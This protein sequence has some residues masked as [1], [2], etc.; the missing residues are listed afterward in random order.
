MKKVLLIV[1]VGLS[2]ALTTSFL[3]CNKCPKPINANG[4]KTVLYSGALKI[5]D[6]ILNNSGNLHNLHLDS[7]SILIDNYGEIDSQI[8][9][10]TM[11]RYIEKLAS[12]YGDNN[13]LVS[14]KENAAYGRSV[15]VINQIKT[16]LENTPVLGSAYADIK[17]LLRNTGSKDEFKAGLLNIYANYERGCPPQYKIRLS[18]MVSVAYSSYQYWE[19]NYDGWVDR[20]IMITMGKGDDDKKKKEEEER[21]KREMQAQKEQRIANLVQADLAGAAVGIGTAVGAVGVGAIASAVV[22]LSWD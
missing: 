11:K 19:N 8:Y 22:A 13:Y 10:S 2:G 1:A 4:R 16:D 6:S 21:K 14:F 12:N 3:A 9:Q 18:T 17:D 20:A 15:S 7:F 5:Y